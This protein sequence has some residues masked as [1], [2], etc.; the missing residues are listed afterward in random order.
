MA[1]S[2]FNKCLKMRLTK[3][4]IDSPRN[5]QYYDSHRQSSKSIA[6]YLNYDTHCAGR[7]D[8]T[9][10]VVGQRFSLTVPGC[11]LFANFCRKALDSIVKSDIV[12]DMNKI[13]T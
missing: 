13:S 9:E 3:L 11:D 6:S 7:K 4:N 12:L 10:P 2:S 5:G 8:E 1:N